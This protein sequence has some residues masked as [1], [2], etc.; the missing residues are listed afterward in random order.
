MKNNMAGKIIRY[1]ER[2]DKVFGEIYEMEYRKFIKLSEYNYIL[3]QFSDN[4]S[5]I[6]KFYDEDGQI[7]DDD[8]YD[9]YILQKFN[10]DFIGNWNGYRD[11]SHSYIVDII[12][13]DESEYTDEIECTQREYKIYTF[14]EYCIDKE[15]LDP[16]AELEHYHVMW[17]T[18]EEEY[19]EYCEQNQYSYENLNTFI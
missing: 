8:G 9:K 4:L 17:D 12:D 18:Y 10:K 3:E 5:G 7:I 14:K 6:E 19:K 15:L 16:K 2:E 13:E 11:A 1:K